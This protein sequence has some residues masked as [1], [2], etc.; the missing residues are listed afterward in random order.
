MQKSWVQ[1]PIVLCTVAILFFLIIKNNLNNPTYIITYF[2]N[3]PLTSAPIISEASHINLNGY[4]SRA[5]NKSWWLNKTVISKIESVPKIQALKAQQIQ[6]L[7]SFM[8][9][10]VSQVNVITESRVVYV[11]WQCIELEMLQIPLDQ[12]IFAAPINGAI[13]HFMRL[14]LY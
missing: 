3:Y 5:L 13:I 12:S 10:V 14:M 11:R 9:K 7:S 1:L 6:H 8:S 4:I 2:Q